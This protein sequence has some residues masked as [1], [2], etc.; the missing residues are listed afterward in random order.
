MKQAA[1]R[2]VGVI[3]FRILAGGALTAEHQRH[4]LAAKLVDPIASGSAYALDVEQARR[5]Q[6]FVS[7][8]WAGSMVEA[9]LRF[10]LSRPEISSFPI[11][12]SSLE[13]IQEAIRAVE[14]GPLPQEALY[15]LPGIWGNFIP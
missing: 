13:Q 9:A 6:F 12:F 10:A 4:P 14:Q 1:N 2:Q 11:G 15:R 5:F 7:E 8:Q 3:A